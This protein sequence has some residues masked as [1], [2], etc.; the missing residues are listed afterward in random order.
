LEI[1]INDEKLDFTLE[2][3]RSLGEVV[4]NIEKWLQ[5]SGL[6]ITSIKSNSREFINDNRGEWEMSSIDSINLLSISV[7]TA[8][9]LH[10]STCENIL[11]FLNLLERAMEKPD[12]ALIDDLLTGFPFV[13]E[14]LKLLF[15]NNLFPI[16]DEL[17]EFERLGKLLA[18]ENIDSNTLADFNDL[19]DRIRDKVTALLNELKYPFE[20]L[21]QVAS[22]LKSQIGQITNVSILLQTGKDKKAFDTIIHFSELFH[23]MLRLFSHIKTSEKL[24]LAQYK[25]GEINLEEYYNNL[26][27]TLRELHEAFTISDFILIG[28]L[29]EYEIAPK[30]TEL[31]RFIEDFDIENVKN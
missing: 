6:I 27:N 29:L 1:F 15:G 23:G 30:I 16:G 20:A 12:R 24:D 28:D 21:K 2:N 4:D 10:I 25:I 5:K 26:N 3:E 8:N 19:I 22:E 7:K 13:V 17:I 9:E 18:D 14:S 31:I 11:T